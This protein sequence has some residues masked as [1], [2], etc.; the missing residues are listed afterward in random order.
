MTKIYN[1]FR[2]LS[3]MVLRREHEALELTTGEKHN[4]FQ[5]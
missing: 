3:R 1:R 4:E 2:Q 5:I